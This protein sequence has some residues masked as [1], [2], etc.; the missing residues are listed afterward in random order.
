MRN[1]QQQCCDFVLNTSLILHEGSAL[2]SF[3]AVI[4][5]VE[6]IRKLMPLEM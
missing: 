2:T 3:V 6:Y 4:R 5:A 1:I